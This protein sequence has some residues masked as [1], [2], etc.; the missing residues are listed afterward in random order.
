MVLIQLQLPPV[1]PCAERQVRGQQGE[2]ACDDARDDR[3]GVFRGGVAV[4]VVAV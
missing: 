4:I 3:A 1:D 2:T